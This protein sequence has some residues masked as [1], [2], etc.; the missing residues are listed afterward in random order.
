[1]WYSRQAS[2]NGARLYV[3]M[4][5]LIKLLAFFFIKVFIANVP[6]LFAAAPGAKL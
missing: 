4:V 3:G 6:L 1:M 5:M 2:R